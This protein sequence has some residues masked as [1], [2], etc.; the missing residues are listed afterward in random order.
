MKTVSKEEFFE[1]LEKEEKKGMD[2]MP[3]VIK[4]RGYSLW[5]N[6]YHKVFG[7]SD[8]DPLGYRGSTYYLA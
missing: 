7:R 5:S 3:R 8:I 4:G 2:I 1:A 6:K